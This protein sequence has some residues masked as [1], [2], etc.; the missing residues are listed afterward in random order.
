MKGENP[1]FSP[2]FVL[3]FCGAFRLFFPPIAFVKKTNAGFGVR[4]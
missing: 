1:A 4:L 3:R 2:F